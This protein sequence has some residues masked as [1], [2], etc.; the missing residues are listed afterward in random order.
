M[1]YKVFFAFQMDVE[2]KFGKGFIQSAIEI[3]IA[4]FRSEG[5]NVSLDFGFRKTPGTPLLIDEM[6]RK[7]NE[8]D[9]VIV[10]LTYTSAKE[11]LAAEIIGEDAD[12]TSIRIP[13]GD[14]K[15]SPNPNVLL[16]TGYA[17]AKKGTYRTLAV[18]NEAY[19]SPSDLPVDLKGFRWGITYNLNESNNENRKAV[20]A[21]LAKDF[22]DAI[23]AAIHSE[24]DYQRDK[25]KPL[26]L[27]KDWSPKDYQTVYLPT[28]NIKE[29]I[30]QL[31]IDL[32][33]TDRPQRIV[34][35]K[36]SG[37]TRLAYELYREIDSSLPKV[38][39]LEKILY[40]DIDGSDYRSIENKLLDLQ[41]L[42][43]R[44]IVILDNCPL[45]IHK[46][47]F[48]EYFYDSHISLLTISNDEDGEGASHFVDQDFANEIIEKISNENGN[49]RNTNF[50]IENAKGNLRNALA[51]I[52]KIPEGSEGFST[53]YNEKWNQLLGADLGEPE[54]LNLLEELSLFTHVGYYDSF[55]PQSE[56]LLSQTG[57]ATREDLELIINK[58]EEIGIVKIAGD[59]IVL[60]VFVEELA[61]NRLEKLA[62]EDVEQFFTKITEIGLSKQF[63]KR[64]I[65]LNKLKGA[66]HLI[67]IL[68]V[69]GGLLTKYEFVNSDQGARIIMGL[70]ELEPDKILNALESFLNTKSNEELIEIKEGRRYLVWAL[71][72]LVFRKQTFNGAAKLLYRLAV[73]E[74]ENIGNNA[75]SQFIQLF[76]CVLPATEATLDDRIELLNELIQSENGSFNIINAAL[77]RG[78]MVHG[79]TR[80]GGAD[81]Q[82]GEKLQ[83]YNPTGAEIF[84]YWED[85]INYVIQ[86]ESYDV[87][88]NRLNSQIFSGNQK[89]MVDAVEKMLEKKSEIDK[90]LRQQ[91][92]YILS[93]KRELPKDIFDKIQEL[94]NKY[95][96]NT[97]REKLEFMVALA[98]YSTY[99]GKDGNIIN[100]SEVKANEFANEFAD[101]KDK[102]W[103]NDLDVLLQDEQRLTFGF[104][105]NIANNNPDY[106][107]LIETAIQKL[108][109]IPF[110]KQNISFIEGY[111]SGILNQDFIR[112]TISRFLKNDKVN[113]H[114]IKLTR[115]LLLEINDLEILYPLIEKN[116]NYAISLQYLSIKTLS[117]DEILN[118]IEWLKNIEPYGWW[119]AIDL[120]EFNFKK[121]LDLTD[122]VLNLFSKLLQREGVL[123]GEGTYNAF[124]MRQYVELLR[125]LE[126]KGLD[127][128]T[129]QFLANEVISATKELSLK[130]ENSIE[131]ILEIIL[132]DYWNISWPIIALEMQRNDFYG[133]YN[134]K[135]LLKAYHNFEESKLLDWMD[136]YPFESPQKIIQFIQFSVKNQDEEVWSALAMEMFNRFAENDVFLQNL[137]SVLHSY[138]WSGS[139]VPLFESRINLLEQLLNHPQVKIQEFAKEN[140][141]DFEEKIERE[142]RK[143]ENYGLE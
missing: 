119:V 117:E 137:S 132:K 114:S 84:K 52:G 35:P 9:M 56:F 70:A 91:F 89:A 15:L 1:N 58:L 50:I 13:K 47:V 55:Q 142:K 87:L 40:Y 77:D 27:H 12:S 8:S 21:E 29:K 122:K 11:F 66:H 134:L 24:S 28:S 112:D 42:N 125:K 124:S 133:W 143:D 6:L 26:R 101:L 20:R 93:E 135:K 43:Q 128:S 48:N 88:V 19:G 38:D 78:L 46:K 71:E 129:V 23:K 140:I 69:E 100:R 113:Y 127:D 36:N 98:P 131:D 115:Y 96:K 2:D 39:N 3:A 63:S 90:N 102:S 45:K 72:R 92:D 107:E 80:M 62:N 123:K 64:L 116:P 22:Y 37:K 16:E 109:Q 25:W 94:L 17:W 7:S 138:F 53:D 10:D 76:Q 33:R 121:E 74:N 103:M 81:L 32:E 57:I 110:E 75:K 68:S 31:R 18:M 79:F 126:A 54:V 104:A 34:G 14:R 5:T 65:E 44:K 30:K 141:I 120:C 49:P 4:K 41:T 83:D 130:H 95:T 118:F 82:A 106:S 61:F 86:L 67:E 105:K 136:Q 99:K 85:I 97:I 60:E 59:F 111:L 139:L 51:M 73:A 108:E